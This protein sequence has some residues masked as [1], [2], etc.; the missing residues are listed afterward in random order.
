MFSTLRRLPYRT[1]S[2]CK[3]G[4]P[5]AYKV[6]S[7]F[8]TSYTFTTKSQSAEDGQFKLPE[9]EIYNEIMN[10]IKANGPNTGDN[11]I[12]EQVYKFI[13][14]CHEH[15][16][17][18]NRTTDSDLE[19]AISF[20][21][22]IIHNNDN[23]KV[24]AMA[25]LSKIKSAKKLQ[26]TI[27]F[28][29][30]MDDIQKYL[31]Q[32]E[33]DDLILFGNM[34]ALNGHLDKMMQLAVTLKDKHGHKGLEKR[35]EI[36]SYLKEHHEDSFWG[37]QDYWNVMSL[38]LKFGLHYLPKSHDDVFGIKEMETKSVK[39]KLK[40]IDVG[41]GDPSVADYR[42]A[43]WNRTMERYNGKIDWYEIHGIDK[44]IKEDAMCI[45]NG[46]LENEKVCIGPW[47]DDKIVAL[48]KKENEEEEWYLQRDDQDA[49]LFVGS[50][51]IG[52]E[53]PE[54]PKVDYMFDCKLVL[55]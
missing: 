46:S 36:E 21:H 9:T 7:L 3:Y 29:Q 51:R 32:W 25:V 53:A 31:N 40:D 23:N 4:I 43:V 12:N 26:N 35:Q 44:V 41:N 33:L 24:R 28:N 2:S 50:Y 45:I 14:N 17:N 20:L 11:S 39:I 13:S 55:K 49:K 8:Q 34:C 27:I 1:Q 16:D 52:K 42:Q 48:G 22:D 18:Q 15:P 54:G 37:F 30:G 6:H 47:F 38:C 19:Y 5:T 10:E